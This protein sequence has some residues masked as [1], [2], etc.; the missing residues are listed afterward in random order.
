MKYF[1]LALLLVASSAIASECPVLT[2]DYVGCV[3]D[4]SADLGMDYTSVSVTQAV[5]ADGIDVYTITTTAK[6]GKVEKNDIVM[7]GKEKTTEAEDAEAG[8]ITTVEV[9]SCQNQQVVT[10][11]KVTAEKMPDSAFDIRM[12][13]SLNADGA[14]VLKTYMGDVSAGPAVTMTCGKKK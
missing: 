11:A 9:D 1:S 8:K 13:T 10:T 3:S 4:S 7:D 6:D 12:E 2:G 5:N 14:L